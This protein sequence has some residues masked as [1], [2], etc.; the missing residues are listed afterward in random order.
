MAMGEL[1]RDKDGILFVV[2]GEHSGDRSMDG[3]FSDMVGVGGAGGIGWLTSSSGC[4]SCMGGSNGSGS[5]SKMA[6]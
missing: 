4:C 3:S 6:G 1:G 5:S 2:E